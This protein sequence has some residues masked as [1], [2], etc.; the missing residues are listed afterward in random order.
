[1]IRLGIIFIILF[2][3]S[4][5]AQTPTPHQSVKQPSDI[6]LAEY[7]ASSSDKNFDFIN[8]YIQK[9]VA[10]VS[11]TD[12]KLGGQMLKYFFIKQE[13]EKW[14]QGLLKF[15]V[16]VGA[17][18]ELAK[19]KGIELKKISVGKIIDKIFEEEFPELVKKPKSN[20]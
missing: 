12:S 13:G 19:E 10:A 7:L 17:V 5:H 1:M 11:E 4:I 8:D 15:E 9:K 18:Q 14:G 2:G 20:K 16:R 6:N 3:T